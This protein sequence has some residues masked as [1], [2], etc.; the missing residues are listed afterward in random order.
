[1]RTKAEYR[2][3]RTR[4]GIT[5]F[6]MIVVESNPSEEWKVSFSESLGALKELYGLAIEAGVKLAAEFHDKSGGTPQSVEIVSLTETASDTKSDA[7]MCAAALAAWKSWGHD[8]NAVR[9]EYR[10]GW[11]VAFPG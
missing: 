11:S 9:V 4:D 7:V 8:E 5:A 6:A 1:M 10:N 2:F 3:M